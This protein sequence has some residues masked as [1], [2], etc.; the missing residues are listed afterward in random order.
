[1]IRCP[2]CGEEN[3]ERFRLCGF[4]GAALVAPLPAQEVRKTVTIVFSDLKGS[5]S[6]GERLDSESLREVMN[7]YFEAMRAEVVQHGGT[8]EKYIGDAIMAVFG[9]PTVHEDDAL[10]AVR[11]A[12]GMR[13]ALRRINE[14]LDRRWG[15]TLANRTG[16]N[17]GEVVAG[18]PAAGQRLVTGDAVNTAARLEQA[19]PE[20]EILVGEL[21]LALVRDAVEVE[22]VPPLELKGKSELV[23]AYRLIGVSGSEGRSRRVDAPIVGREAELAILRDAYREA[24]TTRAPRLVTVIGDAGMGKSRLVRAFVDPLADEAQVLRGRCL[25]YGDG[26]TFWP[27]VEIVRSFAVIHDS[28]APDEAR[29][30]IGE[31]LGDVDVTE[32][33]A[34]AIGLTGA[35]F[36][37]GELFW[38]SRRMIEILGARRP[39]AIVI[40]DIHWAAPTLL[41]LIEQLNE[42]TR[43][44]PVVIL[45]TAR[46]ELLEDRPGWG[47]QPTMRRMVLGRLTDE[48]AHRIIENQLGRTGIEEAVRA[49]IAT[50]AEGNPLFVEQ[51]LSMLIDNGA[52]HLGPGGWE[53]SDRSVEIAVP[54]TIQALIAA[55]LDRLRRDERAVIDPAAVIGLEFDE[56]A[57]EA[58]VP[59]L[60]RPATADHLSSLERRHLV[61]RASSRSPGDGAY[62]F[63]H[64]L[65]R[66]A[67]YHGLLKRTR[68][69]LHERFVEWA[70]RVNAERGRALE[71]EA[72]LGY[73]LEQAHRY[74]AELGPLDAH[75]EEL[76]RRALER[77]RGAGRRA[78]A[79]GD[80]PAAADLLRR[81]SSIAGIG[82]AE[83]SAILPD[84]GEALMEL[85]DFAAATAVLDE[86]IV[87]AD[88][89]GEEALRQR[90]M[91]VRSLVRFYAGDDENWTARAAALVDAAIPILARAGDDAGLA[92]AWRL[93]FGTYEAACRYGEAARAAERILEHAHTAGDGRLE[94]R[95]IAG[96]AIAALYG[97]TPVTD[98]LARCEA[99]VARLSG[100]RRTEGLLFCYMAQLCAMAGDFDRARDL[101]VR[102]RRS[103]EELGTGV[104]SASTSLNSWKVEF[105]AGD[106]RRAATEL[107]RD[108][109]ALD[110]M[111]ERY[112]RSTI[113]GALGQVHYALGDP[114]EAD[115]YSALAEQLAGADDVESQ[116]LW[117]GVR[118]K[119]R[120]LAGDGD[121]AR[122]LAATAVALTRPTE[123]PTML[124]EALMDE[125]E[126]LRLEGAAD[127]AATRCREALDLFE[128]KGDRSS[129]I[130][131]RM[132]LELLMT[133]RE[134][135]RATAPE[136]PSQAAAAG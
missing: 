4:C 21:T 59:D 25:P 108:F 24:V 105:L 13:A 96:Y 14:E 3:P 83:R 66:D 130:R 36:P 68:A 54:P 61:R 112:L 98:A 67:A 9:L 119:V 1:M 136:A 45:C 122:E 31:I 51:L 103:L 29:R 117:R 40:D 84:L 27:L 41:E 58:L 30:K 77:L 106:P 7:A 129:A 35:D 123:A 6:L 125:A 131:A 26:I 74:L 15:V 8:V 101:Y 11:A 70:D 118:A 91:I 93:L 128:R 50:A 71:F 88:A 92:N 76:G 99:L 120:A 110:A 86:C 73:H 104:L 53:R 16:V 94:T 81:A 69:T 44:T 19:A 65:I 90:A 132:Q 113:A 78:F 28:D 115:R 62:R 47:S 49:R 85:G 80:M 33:I 12:A 111:G 95:G 121:G 75:G 116:A 37:L 134:G 114:A 100:D 48:D 52:L 87:V 5:T 127:E 17:T 79:R 124:A 23:P 72:I 18:D 64:G 43:D 135:A 82:D 133:D 20:G 55:R 63:E 107:A 22:P 2:T 10:R 46:H 109:D 57:V 34:S 97:P 42:A 56:A 39:V 38:A 126:V 89:A 60:L 32:R 102:A